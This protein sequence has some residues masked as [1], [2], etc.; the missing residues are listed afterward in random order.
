MIM[1]E[2]KFE[3]KKKEAVEL[4]L[5][6]HE[7]MKLALQLCKRKQRHRHVIRANQPKH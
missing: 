2:C 1:M 5:D 6:P 4:V 7:I 3:A